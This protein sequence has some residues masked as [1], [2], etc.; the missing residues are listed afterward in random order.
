MVFVLE[1][2]KRLLDL[3]KSDGRTSDSV[4]DGSSVSPSH[5]RPLLLEMADAA[6]NQLIEIDKN[7]DM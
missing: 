2:V 7:V 4:F 6:I 3:P 1:N 5:E